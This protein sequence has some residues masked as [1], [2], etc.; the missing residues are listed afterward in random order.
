M[1][2]HKICTVCIDTRLFIHCNRRSIQYPCSMPA[3]CGNTVV[4]ICKVIPYSLHKP[5][6]PLKSMLW[7][8]HKYE[9]H[10]I[11][12]AA[13]APTK[14]FFCPTHIKSIFKFSMDDLSNHQVQIVGNGNMSFTWKHLYTHSSTVHTHCCVYIAQVTVYKIYAH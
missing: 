6:P 2:M 7:C 12:N 1:R 10:K 14:G 9:E 3:L 13:M 5:L 11:Y 8:L 4:R